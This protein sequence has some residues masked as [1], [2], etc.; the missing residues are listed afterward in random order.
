MPDGDKPQLARW[1][2]HGHDLSGYREQGTCM[3]VNPSTAETTEARTPSLAERMLHV[4][5]RRDLSTATCAL[6]G[7]QEALGSSRVLTPQQLCGASPRTRTART[8]G[9]ST[10]FSGGG[11]DYQPLPA[12]QNDHLLPPQGVHKLPGV[13]RQRMGLPQ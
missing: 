10:A 1:S 9:R 6:A 4:S 11:D 2:S 3:H 5:P 13:D 12:R 8:C 7:Q